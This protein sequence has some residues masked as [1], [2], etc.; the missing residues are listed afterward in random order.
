MLAIANRSLN[1]GAM[2]MSFILHRHHT[3][4]SHLTAGA[5]ASLTVEKKSQLDAWCEEQHTHEQLALGNKTS[6]VGREIEEFFK[7]VEESV[8][9][10]TK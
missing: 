4:A 9:E 3:A 2:L 7:D 10:K 8:N 1:K 6:R 5:L